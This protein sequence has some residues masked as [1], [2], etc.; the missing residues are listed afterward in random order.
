MPLDETLRTY[1]DRIDRLVVA[2]DSVQDERDRLIAERDR[3]QA[4]V[5]GLRAMRCTN[6]ACQLCQLN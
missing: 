2:L 1:R 3:L 4:E 6:P 5:N